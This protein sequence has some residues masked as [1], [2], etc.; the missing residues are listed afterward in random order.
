M[1]DMR[2]V[3]DT[4]PPSPD[5]AAQTPDLAT[6][7]L[8]L[9]QPPPD[10]EPPPPDLDSP[11]L[12][13]DTA[14][15]L[16]PPTPDTD[17]LPVDVGGGCPAVGSA[18][19]TGCV[20]AGAKACG[21]SAILSCAADTAG[22]LVWS[23]VQDCA[24]LVCSASGGTPTCQCPAPSGADI[25]VDPVAGNDTGASAPS[26]ADAPAS[27]RF[28]TLKRALMALD[29][30]RTRVVAKS[31]APP[32]SF[33][34]GETFPLVVPAGATLTTAD[35]TP[36]P[37]NYTITFNATTATEAV[38]LA[39]GATLAGFTLSNQGGA[40]GASSVVCR[41]GAVTLRNVIL[42]GGAPAAATKQAVGLAI[43][44]GASDTCTGTFTGLTV[45][46]FAAGVRVETATTTPAQ[47]NDS[48]L[49]D[50]TT[51]LWL[52]AGP[53]TSSR[54]TIDKSASGAAS[55]GVLVAGASATV[56]PSLQ[57]TDLTV[58]GVTSQGL[59]VTMPA[60]TAAPVL[61]LVGGRI[62]NTTS[63]GVRLAGGAL[64]MTGTTVTGA[65]TG[66]T[67]L[68]DGVAILGGSAALK[69]IRVEQSRGRGV[70]QQGG[71]LVLDDDARIRN[72][73]AGL[74]ASGIRHVAGTLT[75]G[76]PSA[77][78]VE[79]SGNAYNGLYVDT[80]GGTGT[81]A[82]TVTRA[83]IHDNAGAGVRIDYVAGG[84]AGTTS[85]SGGTI[86]KNGHGV[87]VLRAPS[88][89]AA[90]PGV[91]VSGAVVR[92]NGD[93]AGEGNGL[94]LGATGDVTASLINNTVRANRSFGVLVEQAANTTASVAMTGNDVSGNNTGAGNEV[95]GV[96]FRA[97]T[98]TAF[99]G[100]RIHANGGIELG[101]DGQP[102]GGAA[103]WDI[104]GGNAGGNQIWCY[105]QGAVG[106]RVQGTSPSTVDARNVSWA[107][108]NPMNNVDYA[109]PGASVVIATM[110]APPTTTPCP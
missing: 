43:G 110:P 53:V 67:G 13:V 84:A 62:E 100:N 71:T 15:D 58:R 106:L 77:A 92:E 105:G 101:F 7:T 4:R 37:A 104:T 91:T 60:N 88:P 6:V 42:V 70:S 80:T 78:P 57:A 12:A 96:L 90:A 52:V 89:G 1:S 18:V 20:A 98:L 47:L 40:M 82:V 63:F 8:D 17:P 38:T 19:G 99:S 44:T 48:T 59:D 50:D 23:Q 108:A 56:A 54:L 32:V 49:R 86:Y 31:A 33:T 97:G 46:G 34:T 87:H 5:L 69:Q 14:A 93:A 11:D 41:A 74:A 81:S 95:G 68:I 25:F 66:S 10:L 76:S 24:G 102:N 29:A 21:G 35:A 39:A 85:I 36:T 3:L 72:N 73:G 64:S 9:A 107:N 26:G 2:V 103:L 83:E 55:D 79:I 45:S 65:G 28:K 27:C 16:A 22:C 109:S 61:T 75:I 94:W 30:T 51:G